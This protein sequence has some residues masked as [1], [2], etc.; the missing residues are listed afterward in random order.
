MVGFVIIVTYSM[1][2]CLIL[3]TRYIN[4]LEAGNRQKAMSKL[5]V[6]PLGAKVIL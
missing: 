3:Q 1:Y 2:L 6:P 4:E 5:R